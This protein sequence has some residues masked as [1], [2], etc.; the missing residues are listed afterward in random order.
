MGKATFNKLNGYELNAIPDLPDIRDHYYEPAL[1]PLQPTIGPANNLLI[2][3]QGQEGACVGFGLAATINLLLT[4]N[5]RKKS[6]SPRMLYEMARKFD[7]W[8]GV[9]YSGSSCRGGI[10]GWY[11]NGVCLDAS[12]P[13]KTSSPEW[14]TRAKAAEAKET[15]IGAYYRLRPH[16]VD[17]HAALN[18]VGVLFASAQVHKGWQSPK[19]GVIKENSTNLGGHAFAVV[20]YNDIGFWVQNSWGPKWGDHGVALWTYEV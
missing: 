7:E 14:L 10:R 4:G 12:W 19:G 18:E 17:Y 20:G 13:Y 2:L 11:H 16:I 15:T 9:A 3:D 6:V 5:D 1:I 8:E